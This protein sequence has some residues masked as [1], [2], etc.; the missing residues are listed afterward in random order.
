MGRAGVIGYKDQEIKKL[1]NKILERLNDLDY[2]GNIVYGDP[3]HIG[4]H[5]KS[6]NLNLT[7]V[8]ENGNP[9]NRPKPKPVPIPT[10]KPKVLKKIQSTDWLNLM[11]YFK[12]LFDG[13][14]RADWG[15]DEVRQ[16]ISSAMVKKTKTYL[17]EKFPD[18]VEEKLSNENK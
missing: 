10:P 13:F 12:M 1:L 4:R 9:V 6:F 7:R 18:F 17:Q 2:S 15:S 3:H 16:Q 14:Q 5:E 8:D 11:E